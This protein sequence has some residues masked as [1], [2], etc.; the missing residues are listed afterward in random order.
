M[1]TLT[2]LTALAAALAAVVARAGD[3]TIRKTDASEIELADTAPPL[4]TVTAPGY[5][6]EVYPTG[7]LR[8]LADKTVLLDGLVLELERE[9]KPLGIIRQEKDTRLVLREGAPEKGDALGGGGGK[10][11]GLG[12][13]KD[14]GADA[15]LAHLPGVI[16]DFFADRVELGFVNL[17]PPKGAP[18]ELPPAY[19]LA[20]VFGPAA[21][22]VRNLRD[23]REDA[24]PTNRVASRH[25][26]S[27]Y[28][29]L[30][31]YWPDVAITYTDGATLTLKDLTGLAHYAI[32]KRDPYT[33]DPLQGL[34]GYWTRRDVKEKDRLV[35][36][37]AR[38]DGKT[39]I[40]PAPYFSVRAAATRGWFF[41]DE[42]VRYHLD[43]SA[44]HLVPGTWKL[45]WVLE[46]HEQRPAGGGEQDVVI[47]EGKV[48]TVAVDLAPGQM[49]YGRARLTLTA[50]AGRSATRLWEFSYARTRPEHPELRTMAE[51]R[52]EDEL[53]W[54]NLLGM[55]GLRLTPAWG[56]I[57]GRHHNDAGDI[58]WAPWREEFTKYLEPARA[59]TVRGFVALVGSDPSE[60]M[61]K[62]YTEKY[63]DAA[64]RG[65]ELAAARLR[66][67]TEFARE[68]KPF[69]V[70]A[71]E[72]VNEPN[73]GTP[74]QRY[75]DDI[76]KP[77]YAAVKAGNPDADFLGG[78]ICGLDNYPWMRKL[79]E[80]GGHEHFD[81]VSMHPYTGNGFE[82][83]YRAELAQWWQLMR[84]FKDDQQALWLTESCW[85]RGWGYADYVY[86]RF[87]A[88]RQSQARNAVAMHL[89][90][91]ALGVPRERIYVFY[92]VEHGY[93][94][95]FLLYRQQ[96]TA[97]AVAIQ[98]MNEC[99]R[100]A[101][102]ERELPL[103]G[104]GHHLQICRDAARTVAVAFT[105]GEAAP[106]VLRTDAAEA[107]VT[108]L[109][110][111]RRTVKAEGG[112]VALTIGG[113][114]TYV[115][116]A[117]GARVDV[118]YAALRVQPNLALTTLGATAD[119]SSTGKLPK[120]ET[121]V[122]PAVALTGDWT[123]YGS[124]LALC[125]RRQGWSEDEANKDQF[126][127]WFEVKL[128]QP[129]PVARVRVYL[130]YGAWERLLRDY[131]VQVFTDGDWRTVA[132][133]RDN[134]YGF[135]SD[136]SF[137]PVTTDRVRVFITKVN[138]CLF[139]QIDWIP[140]VSSLRAV[141]VYGTAGGPAAAFFVAALP[142][143]RVLAAG[144]SAPLS[145]ALRN[146]RD[147]AVAGELRLALPAGVTAE[148][149]QQA[150]RLAPQGE[151]TFTTKVTLAADAAPSLY[152][153]LAGL[154]DGDALISSDRAVR[155][156]CVKPPAPAK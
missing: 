126:P 43:F 109:M 13:G 78:S 51:K 96:P 63:P 67:L 94:D 107:T 135:I 35:L 110:G 69:G 98:V 141:E 146:V 119:A 90:A 36:A 127:D 85:H 3:V 87:G 6:A 70:T 25:P 5:R 111:N 56:D 80:L 138:A 129:A 81:G 32:A 55:R 83:I 61:T 24:L 57:W 53:A 54:A 45:R 123:G 73:L 93:N 137:A 71:F 75:L 91:A 33:N 120:S 4:Y 10:D 99:L 2:W 113:D 118:D 48:P 102:F 117:A 66:F 112:R 41:A 1:R 17:K 140:H 124:A 23:G 150:V 151:A 26:F 8:L 86:D 114:A 136:H 21:V 116:L 92:L 60:Q 79:Y 84:D 30:G 147:T 19:N 42:P 40:A 142:E 20:G 104:P 38:G 88:F 155:V 132:Q 103:P 101:R 58:N 89:N 62:W 68:L 29:W 153:V 65:K 74:Q 106:L 37:I 9:V 27:F 115:A 125:G 39:T 134:T 47:A 152:P 11:D 143:R 28:G 144:A 133:V 100:D 156:L 15:A 59:G 154:Y 108:D 64:E 14:M 7:R 72:P 149:A 121:R 122:P 105:N 130:D 50:A 52:G 95:M 131:D 34:R 77:Q 128:P 97:A 82:E 31:Q 49:G 145:F 76:L 46:D 139:A 16:L 18:K 12:A 22:S 44:A 148:P